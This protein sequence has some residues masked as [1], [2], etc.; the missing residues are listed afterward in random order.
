[1]TTIIRPIILFDGYCNFCSSTID[2]II[3]YD[4]K[5]KFL[6]AASQLGAGL[7]LVEEYK[8]QNVDSVI[9]IYKNKV[10]RYSTAI[11]KVCWLLGLPFNLFASFLIVPPLFRNMIYKWIAKNRYKWF[12]KRSSCKI[13]D[14]KEMDR[15]I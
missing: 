9:L 2:F 11:L 1:M 14:Q 13:P 10:Y 3:K 5:K 8:L 4:K 12:G 7:K 15:F 6:F